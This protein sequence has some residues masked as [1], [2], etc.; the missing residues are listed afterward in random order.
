MTLDEITL[1]EIMRRLARNRRNRELLEDE[2][3]ALLLAWEE[4][5]GRPQSPVAQ[6]ARAR[7]AHDDL[8]ITEALQSMP[9]IPF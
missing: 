7:L 4:A 9:S 5:E 3:N 6:L 8:A 2:R 1:D